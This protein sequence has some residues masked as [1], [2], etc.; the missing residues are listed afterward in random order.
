MSLMLF[1]G[2]PRQPIASVWWRMISLLMAPWLA[3]RSA[4]FG[5]ALTTHVGDFWLGI[6][7]AKVGQV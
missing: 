3:E 7:F 2:T 4:G 1:Q 6:L 5:L